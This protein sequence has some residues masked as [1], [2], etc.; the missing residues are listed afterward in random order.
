[1]GAAFIAKCT[2]SLGNVSLW[3]ARCTE[4]ILWSQNSSKAIFYLRDKAGGEVGEVRNAIV[5]SVLDYDRGN[6]V[7]HLFWIDDDVLVFPGCLLNL[8]EVSKLHNNAP[9][10]SGVYFTKQ[11]GNLSTPLIFREKHGGPDLF[12]P[13]Q[14]YPVWGHGM[15]LT[16]VRTEVYKKMR[17]ELDLGLD[18]YGLPQWYHTSTDAEVWQDEHGTIHTAMTEDLWFCDNAAKLGIQPIISTHKHAF[19]FHYESAPMVKKDGRWFRVPLID[20]LEHRG[21]KQMLDKGYPEKQWKAWIQGAPIVWG[22]PN[23]PVTWT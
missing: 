20:Y 4:T 19:G 2:P 1:M 14:A 18:K 17:D 7:S 10:V 12:I 21:E 16:L 5:D 9:I 15:G 8:L 6:P 13:D 22:T 3:W 23:G 11:E